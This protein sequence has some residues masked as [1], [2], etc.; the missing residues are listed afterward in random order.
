MLITPENLAGMYY[1][2]DARFQGAFTAVQPWYQKL[3]TEVPS[4]TKAHRYHWMDAMPR[5]RE[6]IGERL[7]R[8]L[9]SRVFIIENK[10][11]ELTVE[12]PK[13]D[14]EDDQIGVYTQRVEM[15]GRQARKWPDDILVDLIQAGTTTLCADG[16]YFFDTD[17]PK[18]YDNSAAGT[19][20][21]AL[22][23]A[24]TATNF[25]TARAAMR[26]FV[27]ADA[28]SLNAEGTLLVVPPALEDTAR[29]IL[30][31]EIIAPAAA[32]GG[33]AANVAATNIYKGAADL[34]VVP[35]FN[36]DPTRWYLFDTSKPI[37]PF[38]FQMRKTPTFVSMTAPTD[39]NVFWQDVFVYGTDSRGNAGFTMP[40]LALT[41]K[42]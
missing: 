5:M 30:N 26:G 10:K 41:S 36:S 42:P 12:V 28:R 6:W 3:A 40:F 33:N 29:A 19:Y 23:V 2:F 32:W 31:S 37:K 25:G 17:H 13:D 24:L 27:G 38:I 16:Q 20:S 39:P 21:N 35:E 11:Y 7:V 9:S 14:I 34:L 1:G 22:T 15:M 8:N 4:T 18:N